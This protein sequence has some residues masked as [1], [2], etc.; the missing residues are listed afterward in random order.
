M[1]D[2]ADAGR[3][4]SV[5]TGVRVADFSR[6]LA[7]PYATMLLADFGAEVI[8]IE[9]PG[10]DDT[11]R[12]SPP[13]DARGEAT[14]FGSVNRGK[15]S[16]M[17]DLADSEQRAQ[18]WRLASSADVVVDNFRP[19]VMAKFGL[20]HESLA[21]ENPRVITCTITGFGEDS[22][23]PGYDLLVQ[24]V[25]GLMSITGESTGP[26]MKAGV[27]LVDVLAGHNA[28]AGILLALRD[29]ERTGRG[30]AVT[31][32]LLQ[33]L[34]SALV[35]QAGATLATGESPVRRG[36]EHPSIAP[37]AVFQ[38]KDRPL[39]IAVGN[40]R[41]FG[42]LTA[43]LGTPDLAVDPR[44]SGNE[45]RVAHRERL[46]ALIEAALAVADAA[47]WVRRFALVGVPAGVVN[48]VA[49]ALALAEE[50]G[51]DPVVRTGQV[52]S[53]ATAIGLRDAPARYDLAP[54]LLDEH[55]DATWKER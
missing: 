6:V 36:N 46:T 19:G 31:V 48:D 23:L 44:F 34:L 9:P 42:A 37:Y 53:V 30:T 1:D 13:V 24:A 43:V 41:Q 17:L 45:Q 51:L 20:D 32:S 7:G 8:K 52:M 4:R 38:A 54:P 21:R 28:L 25:G 10:G 11:R 47:E 40:D 27:A 14:Y 29:R 2:G 39:V 33:S 18:A 15:R 55:H 16:T 12:W 26:G 49:G 50:L 22:S 35:N 3:G 5:L